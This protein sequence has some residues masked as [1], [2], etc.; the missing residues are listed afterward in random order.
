M[1]N[2]AKLRRS[3]RQLKR[4]ETLIDSVY[5]L[6]L[7]I[8]ATELPIPSNVD[9]SGETLGKFWAAEVGE[10]SMVVIG[11]V[12]VVFYWI[13]NN[14]LFGNLVRTNNIHTSVSLLQIFFV[15]IYLY[16][17]RIGTDPNLE[18]KASVL[19]LQSIA[20]ALIGLTTVASWWYA[21]K[22]RRLLS[23]E[24]TQMD[25]RTL[26][27]NFLAEPITALITL[28]CSLLGVTVWSV[29]WLVYPL[30]AWLL[31]RWRG[32]AKSSQL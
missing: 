14:V 29:A 28:P 1:D 25:A 19:A 7:V 9:W 13:Q 8:L 26:Q 16:A 23:A 2:K 17:I 4:L 3:A 6:V 31:E 27:V 20:A 22:N 15:L 32:P 5:A 21:S 24:I 11:L 18:G 12:L 30:V 10:L